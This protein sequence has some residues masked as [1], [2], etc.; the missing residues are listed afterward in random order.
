MNNA[1]AVKAMQEAVGKSKRV[2]PVIRQDVAP[3]SPPEFFKV[4][5]LAHLGALAPTQQ[6]WFWAGLMPAGHLTYLGGH[7]GAGK[8]TLGL[9]LAC[10]IAT[11][12]ACLG[13]PTKAA[14]VLFFSGEDPEDLVLRRLDRICRVLEMDR[15]HLRERLHVIDA[16]DFD[17]VL[18]FER[19]VDG[20]RAGTTTPTYAALAEYVEQHEIDVLFVDNASDTFEADEINRALV[21]AFIRALVRLVRPRNGAVTLMAH[22]DKGTSRAARAGASNVEAYSGSTA[23]HNSARSRLFLLETGPGAFELQH[24]KSNLGPKQD[25]IA[26]EWPHDGLLQVVPGAGGGGFLQGMADTADT[27]ALL[28]LIHE[29]YGRG[30]FVATATQS[31]HHAAAL[32]ADEGAY[33]KRK[34][35]E[36]FGLLRDAERKKWLARERYRDANRKEHERWVL[37]PEGCRAVGV[38]PCAPC[39]PTAD[40]KASEDGASG[41]RH[42]RHVRSGVIGG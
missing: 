23:W 17:P 19:R 38:A 39:A 35:K 34:P 32:L 36:V 18:F 41:A 29:F 7:G 21:R 11:G 14:R 8:S 26:L 5:S 42:V 6:E 15:E 3:P 40:D 4:V 27:R 37:T 13:K 24:Q 20:M 9:M 28:V 10:C 31:R 25:P 33:P 22:V 16:T 12:R 2:V 30:E 1:G